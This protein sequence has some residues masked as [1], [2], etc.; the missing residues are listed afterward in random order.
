VTEADLIAHVRSAVASYKKPKAVLIA[1]E[2]PRRGFAP[3]YDLLDARYGGG[4]Y[5]GS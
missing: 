1:E 5:P 4:G 2:I 3:D